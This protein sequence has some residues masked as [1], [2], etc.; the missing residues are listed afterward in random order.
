MTIGWLRVG[1]LICCGYIL[2]LPTTR[3]GSLTLDDVHNYYFRIS[4]DLKGWTPIAQLDEHIAFVKEFNPKASKKAKSHV[5][6]RSLNSYGTSKSLASPP[7]A[8]SSL[9]EQYRRSLGVLRKVL[10]SFQSSLFLFRLLLFAAFENADHEL[11]VLSTLQ[12]GYVLIC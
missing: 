11:H 9:S 6:D 3:R 5:V 12:V 4:S 7:T 10:D 1:F 8:V 2:L